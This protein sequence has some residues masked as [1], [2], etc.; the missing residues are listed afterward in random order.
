MCNKNKYKPMRVITIIPVKINEHNPKA[1]SVCYPDESVDYNEFYK[2]LYKQLKNHDTQGSNLPQA[3][4]SVR[5]RNNDN[6]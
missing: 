2:N 5:E 6:N 1:Q 3:E 4:V